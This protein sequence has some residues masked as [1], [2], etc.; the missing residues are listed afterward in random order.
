MITFPP[1]LPN[2]EWEE[3]QITRIPDDQLRENLE[4]ILHNYIEFWLSDL[5]HLKN[6]IDNNIKENKQI[7]FYG[8]EYKYWDGKEEI[9]WIKPLYKNTNDWNLMV[10]LFDDGKLTQWVICYKNIDN[11]IIYETWKFDN[12]GSLIEWKKFYRDKIDI[13]EDGKITRTTTIQRKIK[14]ETIVFDE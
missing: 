9:K 6:S 12:N 5:N 7:V 13:I 8:Q 14:P 11:W 1:Y 4:K 2:H 3:P 10:W